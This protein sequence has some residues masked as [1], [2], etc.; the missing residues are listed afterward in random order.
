MR[1][2]DNIPVIVG[3]GEY[4]DRPIDV[5]KSLEPVDLMCRAL[6]AADADAGGGILA[7]AETVELVA[8]VSW[9]YSDP[10]T[11][12][13]ERLGI[14]P[15][16]KTNAS[17][18]GETPIR[19][20]HEAAV[21]IARG[22]QRVAAIV[23]GEATHARNAAK[24]M[25][26]ALPWTPMVSREQAFQ[27]PFSRLALSSVARRLGITEPAQIYPFYEVAA[28]AAWGQTPAAANRDSAALWAKFAAV[29]ATNELAWIRNSPDA[30]KIGTP[31]ADNRLINW[32]YPKFM[33]ANPSV[34]LAAGVLVTSLAVAKAAGVPQRKIIH[35][36]GGA[37]ASEPED[38]LCRDSYAHSTAQEATLDGAVALV[39]GDVRR[40]DF[41]ELYSCFPVV[42]K[43]AMRT[44]KRNGD[45]CVPTVTG[46]LT[47]FGG[48]L[49][50]YMSHA[51]AA[52]ARSLRQSPGAVG[53]LY[54]QGGYVNKHH[55][56]VVS[57]AA[58]TADIKLEYS[59]QKDADRRRGPV[60]PLNETYQGPAVVETYTVLY[61]RDGSALQGIVITR[62]PQGERVMARVPESDQETLAILQDRE[63][64]AV[65]AP[66][67]V[68]FDVFGKPNWEAG[69]DARDRKRRGYRFSNVE[70]DGHL[71]IVTIN[72]PDAL[73]AFTP[74]SNAELAEIFD[75]FSADP[76]QWVAIIT[77]AGTKAFSAGNDLKFLAQ[78][79]ARGAAIENPLAGFGGLTA[80]FDCRKPL[81]AAVNGVAMGG[82][83]EVALACDLIVASDTA[84]FAL[85]EP[86]VG[87]AAVAGGL[88][89]LPQ[90]IGLKRAMAMILTGRRVSA[91]EG[92]TLGFVNEVV[93][94]EELLATARR[95][96]DEI[97]AN[98]PM[99]LR[100]SKEI[101]LRGMDE[102]SIEV[103]YQAQNHYPAVKALFRSA[104]VR[105]GP[106]A[107]AEKRPP[108]W[109]GR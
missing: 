47:F 66:G 61:G 51:V 65:G 90:Q 40:F 32:P 50:N 109:T 89:R 99:S 52:M 22:E 45:E 37:A 6:Q 93:A 57:T 19:L 26:Q 73:N 91:A 59:V 27:F 79:M 18:G 34:N 53:L 11:L 10:V 28:Q 23:G 21:R 101:V 16:R 105:E 68:R 86:K 62:N 92:L 107:F 33:V 35:I 78:A 24:R 97:M 85:P 70:R 58:P 8:I 30:E 82:G 67:H 102:S 100:A 106:L 20:I 80:R 43:M 60:P 25:K 72:R 48:P 63:K 1:S 103:A 4:L 12:L 15:A 31:T 64:S 13:C 39:D 74:E 36:W 83:F 75:E 29:A 42:P 94:P 54:G 81:I 5:S 77:G 44:L 88:L 56:L 84:T 38:F 7:Q 46:G 3:V 41:L 55:T 76:D 69:V 95:W 2:D 98:S 96:A 17:M 71:T 9:R 49:N 14:Q 104:D 87:L 108:R